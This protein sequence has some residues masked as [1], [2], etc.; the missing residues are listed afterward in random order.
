MTVGRAEVRADYTSKWTGGRSAL[1]RCWEQLTS[2]CGL[3]VDLG[4]LYIIGHADGQRAQPVRR[5][6]L[7]LP[8][9]MLPAGVPASSW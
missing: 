5:V 6:S 1:Y 2:E 8:S 4:T 9:A 7:R 3:L